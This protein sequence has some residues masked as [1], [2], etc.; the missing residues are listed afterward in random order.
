M[1]ADLLA[2]GIPDQRTGRV[3]GI[4]RAPRG[5]DVGRNLAQPIEVVVAHAALIW[6]GDV[7]D[8]EA[9]APNPGGHLRC[10][11]DRY[12]GAR[13]QYDAQEHALGRVT[14]AA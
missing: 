1:P 9:Q 5:A 6:A 2:L 12:L 14:L 10:P 11:A 13:R 3:V 7:D 4:E 8:L